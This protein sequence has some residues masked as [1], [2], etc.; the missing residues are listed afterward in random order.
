MESLT[1]REYKRLRAEDTSDPVNCGNFGSYI[2]SNTK[3]ATKDRSSRNDLHHEHR[4]NISSTIATGT[5]FSIVL[6]LDQR[7]NEFS[8]DVVWQ[9]QDVNPK[10]VAFDKHIL[11]QL[12]KRLFGAKDGGVV[13]DTEVQGC[14][15][16]E[17]NGSLYIAHPLFRKDHPWFDWVYIDWDGYDDP[18]PARIDMFIDLR[19]ARISNGPLS[20]AEDEDLS[21]NDRPL[22]QFHHLF[23]ENK[24]YAVVWSAKSLH[25]RRDLQTNHHLPLQ[26][27]YRIELERYRRIVPVESFVKPCYG[28][29]NTCGLTDANAFDN[30][31]VILKERR[32]W[33]KHFL[34]PFLS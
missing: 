5:K 30:T 22:S 29:L 8:V 20:S 6:D 11:C 12:G 33:A 21:E 24:L 2:N 28:F 4:N 9:E 3:E 10:L 18:I 23:L 13:V 31:A 14:T 25:L 26:L 7:E 17:V 1:F 32:D 27:G 34:Y 19:K 16:V 15:A